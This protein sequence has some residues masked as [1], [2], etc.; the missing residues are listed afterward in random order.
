M[1][2]KPMITC[3]VGTGTSFVNRNGETGLVVASGDAAAVAW[4]MR[5]L[6]DD[7]AL[8]ARMGVAARRHYLAELTATRMAASY[9]E[10]YREIVGERP[11]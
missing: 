1:F 6:Y 10:L 5:R 3:E 7:N 9:A 2:G 4:A 8:A 11:A